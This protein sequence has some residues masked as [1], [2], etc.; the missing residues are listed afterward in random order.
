MISRRE[1]EPSPSLQKLLL[2]SISDFRVYTK[3]EPHPAWAGFQF[4]EKL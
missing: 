2:D 4:C 1:D 3:L